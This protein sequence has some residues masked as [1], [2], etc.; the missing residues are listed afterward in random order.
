MG[1]VEDGID[2]G[3]LARGLPRVDLLKVAH[4][5]SRTATT[6]AF[7]DAVRPRVAVASAG[8]GNTYG[9]PAKPTLDRLRASGARVYRT[10]QDGSVSVE[11]GEDGLHVARPAPGPR[12]GDRGSRAGRDARHRGR[13]RVH[14]RHPD[15]GRLAARRSRAPDD[16]STRRKPVPG[17]ATGPSPPATIV[18]MTIPGRREAARLLTSLEPP[19]WFVRHACA[20]ADVA[21]WLAAR[22]RAHGTA[23]DVGLVEAAALL[24]D[25]DKLPLAAAPAHLRHGDGSAAWLAAHG[26][27]ELG[28]VVR[29][30]P[31]TRLAERPSRLGRRPHRPRPGSWRTR[32][33]A[34][35]SGSSRWT[36][37]SP[38][39]DGA[40]RPAGTTTPRHS[41]PTR[42]RELERAVCEAAG[43]APGDVRRLRWS[44]R[45]TR[46]RLAR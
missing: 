23:V 15:P 41:S 27:A 4:H 46:G 2:P 16:P 43:V 14:L 24:H 37:A 10:D 19:A 9:H 1:D 8:A 38:R 13:R 18:R 3:L 6:Q 44:G 11:L 45:A 42:A 40:T 20:V 29:D 32:T 35:A 34:R 22:T 36:P 5:G 7:V 26:M 30:H 21:A 33:S 39:G 17:S 12:A 31:V 25:V 28:P